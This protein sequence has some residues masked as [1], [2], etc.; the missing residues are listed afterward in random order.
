LINY[1]AAD[2]LQPLPDRQAVDVIDV[3]N[4]RLP[5]NYYTP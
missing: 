5:L 4:D 3:E 2:P 1:E